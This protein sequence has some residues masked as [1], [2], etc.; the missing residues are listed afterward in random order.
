MTKA[1]LFKAKKVVAGLLALALTFSNVSITKAVIYMPDV[2]SDM[3]EAS[4]WIDKQVNTDKVLS[5][6]EKIEAINQASISA[7][8]TSLLNLKEYKTAIDGQSISDNLVSSAK[9][10]LTARIG[11]WYDEEGNTITE[12][13]IKDIY[14]N[15]E[16]TEA[17]TNTE[18]KYGVVVDP[19]V[20]T[21]YP[22]DKMLLDDPGDSDFDNLYLSGIRLNEPV[23][24]KSV[25]KDKEYY[26]V[27][28]AFCP[29]WIEAEDVA[30]CADKEE[31]L[32]AWDFAAEGTLV[33]LDDKMYT[34]DSN[35][36]PDTANREL[37]MGTYVELVADEDLVIGDNEDIT[38]AKGVIDG[39]N[40]A[41]YNNYIV[42][43]PVR[44]DD[45]NY[46]KEV[47]FISE[48]AQVH[49]GYVP[50]TIENT[51]NIAF[52][53]LGNTYGW[54]GMLSANDCSGYLR[55]VYACFGLHLARNTTWQMNMPVKKYDT[56][57]MTNEE[58]MA[59]LDTL[60]AGSC[61]YFSGHT[62]IYLGHEGDKYYVISSAS[63]IMNP[64]E[65]GRQRARS[66][67]I[68]TLDAKRA[69][70]NTWMTS[71][72]KF[73]VPY[74]EAEDELPEVIPSDEPSTSASADPGTS[75]S[76]VPTGSAS[77]APDASA[78]A[79]PEASASTDPSA[80]PASSAAASASPDSSDS[81][82]L[83]REP[84][85]G[86]KVKVNKNTYKFTSVT[87]GKLTV[88]LVKGDTSAKNITIPKSIELAFFYN[89][90]ATQYKT[91]KVTAIEKNAFKGNKKVKTITIGTNV[92][93]L[94]NNLFKNCKKLKKIVIKTKMLKAT[95]IDKKAFSGVKKKVV[96]QV[97]KGK[98][99]KYQKIFRKKGL[100]KKVKVKA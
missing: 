80:S 69:N 35:T 36:N 49:E 94:E 6:S 16:N 14:E 37:T 28:S 95:N 3:S 87:T 96:I 29:G 23:L 64:D 55:D 5:T 43:L 9:T 31:W 46:T 73:T 8:G 63:S 89:D 51:M 74:L 40:R 42:Y 91:Y 30:I 60:P 58:K 19:S 90:K 86:D 39:T 77:T 78:S 67:M 2:T 70:G 34:E 59:L 10:E 61:L 13:Y 22:T 18:A 20:L 97:P 68:N 65:S 56:S 52:N 71:L 72:I 33:V 88:S 82:T 38:G 12:E 17:A 57:S 4:Y 98:K 32:S 11:K 27:E 53:S 24:I 81:A 48:G 45:G 62:M 79:A 76:A 7:E 15:A 85:V 41:G 1:K 93:K 47:T 21:A 100:S 84:K 44:D 26:Y 66:V 83:Q 50:L 54:G 75:A 25:S 92:K 99:S